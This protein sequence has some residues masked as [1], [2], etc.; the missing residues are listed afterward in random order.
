MNFMK[1]KFFIVSLI[2]VLLASNISAQFK[3]SGV[4]WDESYTFD[5]NNVTKIEFYQNGKLMRTMTYRTCY[6][7]DGD[8]FDVKYMPE[9]RGM[10]FETVL[11]KKSQVGIQIMGIPG[12]KT[13][14]YNAGAYKYIPDNELKKLDLVATSETKS[15][16]GLNCK[17]YTYTYQKIFGEVWITDEVNLSNDL[18]MF[19]SCKMIA[20]HN[21]L[22]VPGF[23]MEMTT[24][25][26]KGGKTLMTTVSLK[27]QEK[28]TV[29]LKGV[30]MSTA[31]NKVSYFIINL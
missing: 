22:S 31:I 15:I 23:V 26:A 21:T 20:K 14:T 11:D 9:G 29:N 16:A 1:K 10:A 6:Q 2:S 18:G 19:R 4:K 25:D 3:A 8:N 17:K 12:E 7:S 5:L 24:E 27:N 28:Y 13:T 30:D